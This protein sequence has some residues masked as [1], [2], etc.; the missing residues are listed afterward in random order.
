MQFPNYTSPS[1][2]KFIKGPE[3]D[4][5]EDTVQAIE[6]DRH[7]GSGLFFTAGWDGTIKAW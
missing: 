4:F 7:N 3:K 5:H 2:G 1:I 6:V